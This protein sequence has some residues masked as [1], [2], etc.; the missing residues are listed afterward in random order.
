MKI[1]KYKN[2]WY[3][4]D[5]RAFIEEAAES[6]Q[7]NMRL[8]KTGTVYRFSLKGTAEHLRKI[9]LDAARG[10]IDYAASL[11]LSTFMFDHA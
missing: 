7:L 2:S 3:Q 10:N 9:F 4:G 1:V 6:S 11:A 5:P 8:N